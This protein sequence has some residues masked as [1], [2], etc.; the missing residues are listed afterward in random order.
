MPAK[1][2]VSYRGSVL[3]VQPD[4]ASE[5]RIGFRFGCEDVAQN[6]R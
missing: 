4:S 1:G 6:S 5:R 3:L 2:Q